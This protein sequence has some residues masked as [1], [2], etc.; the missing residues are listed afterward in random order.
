MSGV[1]PEP[2]RGPATHSALTGLGV[3]RAEQP[4]TATDILRRIVAWRDS[5]SSGV[6]RGADLEALI[7]EARAHVSGVTANGDRTK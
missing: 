5:V 7:D 1:F 3:L 4:A 2:K 6:V